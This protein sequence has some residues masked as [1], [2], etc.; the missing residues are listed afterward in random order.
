M[1]EKTVQTVKKTTI[2]IL[3]ALGVVFILYLTATFLTQCNQSSIEMNISDYEKNERSGTI[4]SRVGKTQPDI[5]QT[6]MILNF[7]GRNRLRLFS[8]ALPKLCIDGL[9][10]FDQAKAPRYPIDDN[11]SPEAQGTFEVAVSVRNQ[12]LG[13]LHNHDVPQSQFLSSDAPEETPQPGGISTVPL[14]IHGGE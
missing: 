14:A 2:F 12:G 1:E 8:F 7:L 4:N 11:A 13:F 6:K 9:P 10:N 5:S 3:S